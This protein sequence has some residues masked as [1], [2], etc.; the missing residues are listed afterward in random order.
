MSNPL[1][2]SELEKRAEVKEKPDDLGLK[3]WIRHAEKTH[4][5]YL[6]SMKESLKDEK[7]KAEA[8]VFL[9]RLQ[10]VLIQIIPKHKDFKAFELKV[11]DADFKSFKTLKSLAV[12]NMDALEALNADLRKMAASASSIP[13]STPSSTSASK[14]SSNLPSN[15]SNASFNASSNPSANASS[16]GLN[17][18]PSVLLG[19]SKPTISPTSPLAPSAPINPSFAPINPSAPSSAPIVSPASLPQ[20]PV[21]KY[22][23]SPQFLKNGTITSEELAKGLHWQANILIVDTRASHS[24]LSSHINGPGVNIDPEVLEIA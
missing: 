20:P 12:K 14:A 19:D 13:S 17:K 22:S 1:S 4:Q 21:S 16:N 15:A 10:K 2:L 23:L 5:L 24:F 6:E 8:Y 7:K 18:P 3:N 9:L 11:A